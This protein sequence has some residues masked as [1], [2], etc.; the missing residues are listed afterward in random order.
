MM[1]NLIFDTSQ[2]NIKELSDTEFYSEL[3]DKLSYI[4]KDEFPNNPQKQYIK[5]VSDGLNFACPFCGDSAT[6]NRKKR[7]H[8][9]LK[10]KWS[11]TF[12]CFNCGKFMKIPNF[13]K[14]FNNPISLSAL[15]YVNNHI[16][17]IP[18][19][20]SSTSEIMSEILDK[21]SIIKYSITRDFIKQYLHLIEID[22]NNNLSY[23]G[24][25]YL[26]NRCQYNFNNFLYDPT[27]KY[28]V[29]L[30]IIDNDKIFGLQIRDITGKKKAKY[31]TMSLSKIHKNI[32]KDNIE[33]PD[34][35]ESLS[36]VFNIFNVNLY[37][38]VL[39]TEGPFDAFLLPNCIA[40]SGA[41]KSIGIELPFYFVYDSDKTGNEHALKMLN[42]GYHV[43]MW[44]KIK[45]ELGLPE[46]NPYSKN[47][48][49][50]DINDLII[51]CRDNNYTQKIY[52]SKYFTN[53][54]LDGLDI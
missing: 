52:W 5:K 29:I 15:T 33:I 9:I 43:F 21:E 11:G 53:D 25:Q 44:N 28:I 30:N 26:I 36:T 2:L 47:K 39:V 32:L 49:K 8:F 54:I 13:F 42:N 1:N 17:D 24:Y 50:W 35:I 51:W 3:S 22:K 20:N 31:L 7:A 34:N 37:Q 6:D 12:K 48:N 16:N 18:T 46:K 27:G 45:Q 10:G 14:Q 38:P 41:S 19:Y 23:P 40:T 4:L